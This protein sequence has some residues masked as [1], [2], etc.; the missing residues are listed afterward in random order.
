MDGKRSQNAYSLTGV[1]MTEK[2]MEEILCLNPVPG[3]FGGCTVDGHSDEY[4]KGFIDGCASVGNTREAAK[5][6]Q[7]TNPF[8]NRYLLMLIGL[9]IDRWIV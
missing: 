4:Y 9:Y 5:D 1:I 3:E 2:I 8:H 7:M 6:S